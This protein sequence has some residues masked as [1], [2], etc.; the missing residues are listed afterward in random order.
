MMSRG[1]FKGD[2][3]QRYHRA[4]V[5]ARILPTTIIEFMVFYRITIVLTRL[6]FL[7]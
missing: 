7:S 2:G 1:D 3:F 4:V 6:A 5:G